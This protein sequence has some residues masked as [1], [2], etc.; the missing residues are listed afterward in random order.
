MPGTY[1]FSSVRCNSCNVWSHLTTRFG[2]WSGPHG[3]R[4]L[5]AQAISYPHAKKALKDPLH[6]RNISIRP[7]FLL[8]L[9]FFLL[10][11]TCEG[12][13]VSSAI[14]PWLLP[15]STSMFRLAHHPTVYKQ[16]QGNWPACSKLCFLG[17]RWLVGRSQRSFGLVRTLQSG[18]GMC[19]LMLHEHHLHSGSYRSEV[20]NIHL[21]EA[22]YTLGTSEIISTNS[23]TRS[24]NT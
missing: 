2:I 20:L 11:F 5:V 23:R 6:L 4:L 10:Q 3:T 18:Q 24:G 13:L 16:L 19:L 8:S 7:V 9:T 21:L 17:H 15:L 1:K 14:P 12:G 22:E